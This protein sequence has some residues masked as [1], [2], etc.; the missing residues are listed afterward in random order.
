MSAKDKQEG[1]HDPVHVEE[2]DHKREGA[3]ARGDE[4]RQW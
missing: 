3:L 2:V 1:G 4:M